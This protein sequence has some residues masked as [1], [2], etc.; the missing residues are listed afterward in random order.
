MALEAV[1]FQ[2]VPF[3]NYDL[4]FK[5]NFGDMVNFTSEY[6]DSS[7]LDGLSGEVGGK[8]GL[9]LPL[10]APESMNGRRKRRRRVR[11]MK[12]GDEMESQRM[13]HIEAERNRRKQM[14]EYL[15]IIRSLMPPSYTLRGD[16]ASIV[17]AAINFVKELEHHLQNLEAQKHKIY[18]K[19][20][21]PNPF[22]NFFTFPQYSTRSS[23]SNSIPGHESMAEKISSVADVEVSMVETHANIKISSGKQPKQL[24]KLVTGF[25]SLGLNILHLNV[26]T[27][28]NMALY[29]LNVKV[30]DEAHLGTVDN[31]AKIIHE[32]IEKI[33]EVP[34][35]S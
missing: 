14:N 1:V 19:N 21:S 18:S 26:T 34:I 10:K 20:Y 6:L 3:E 16:Q 9:Y 8:A 32:M 23:D 12:N 27:V 7:S 5:D 33:Q 35:S 24:V 13:T 11:S 25:Y 29:S 31:V 28:D 15:T 4:G 2:Q 17:G 30:E 22:A